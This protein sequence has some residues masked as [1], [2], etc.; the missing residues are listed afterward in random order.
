MV[1]GEGQQGRV[2][3]IFGTYLINKNLKSKMY[4]S[5][6]LQCTL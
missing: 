2:W 5:K 6:Y 3:N 1:D 4:I